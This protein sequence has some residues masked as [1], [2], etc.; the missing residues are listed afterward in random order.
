M[1]FA[2]RRRRLLATLEGPVLLAAGAP[3][4]RNYPANTW[5]FRADSNFLYLFDSPEPDSAALLDPADGSVTLFLP[6]RTVEDALWSGVQEP[7]EQVKAGQ[8]VDAVLPLDALE[9]EVK[10]RAKGRRVDSL[11]ISDPRWTARLAA[12]TGQ[13]LAFDAPAKI[14]A[15]T[16]VDAL[17]ALRLKKDQRE[18]AEMAETARVTCEAHVAAMR[19]SRAGIAEEELAGIVE[20]TFARAGCTVA[21]QTILSVRGEVLHNH[22]HHGVLQDGDIVLLD[23]GAEAPSGYCTDVTRCWPVGT[24]SPEGRDV[25]DLVLASEEAAI[26]AVKPGVRYRDVHLLACRVLAQGL[27][28]L[29]LL[30]G[31]VDGLVESGAHAVFFPHGVGHQLGLDVHDLE[32]FGDRVLYPRGRTRSDQFGTA[33]LRMDMDLEP[34]MTF[35]IEPGLYFV[36]AI[37]HSDALR[38]RFAGQVRFDRAEAYLRLNGGRGFGGVRIEDNV[39]CTASGSQVLTQAIPKRRAEVEALAGS[40]PSN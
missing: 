25:Y 40:A 38:A 18:L 39:L 8:K 7:F 6:A 36:P 32:A 22:S 14:G 16:L 29:G 33:Y 4:S 28:D 20:G 11:A 3:L 26:A 13:A 2:S 9:V 1:D 5:P 15:P 21:Y 17:S 37:L 27:C 19:H 10:A 34:G 12:I 30:S 23:A 24:F 35:T 31:S